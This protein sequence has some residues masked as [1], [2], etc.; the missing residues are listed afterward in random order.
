MDQ[1]T[2]IAKY[3]NS[4][5]AL[6]PDAL[7]IFL[8]DAADVASKA[9]LREDASDIAEALH[10]EGLDSW[11][12]LRHITDAFLKDAGMR[13]IDAA[14]LV[15]KLAEL[16]EHE[17]NEEELDAESVEESGET[18]GSESSADPI[19]SQATEDVRSATT[20]LV[21]AGERLTKRF[22]WQEVFQA[23]SRHLTLHS[24]KKP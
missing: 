24:R 12:D 16:Q 8:V 13:G 23:G 2:F 22:S 18:S 6:E 9:K 19:D 10:N 15:R 1:S 21:S 5:G 17:E 11:D 14:Y 20:T 4:T 3:L 7:T